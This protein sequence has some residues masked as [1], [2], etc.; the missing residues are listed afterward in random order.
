[1]S[2]FSRLKKRDNEE[3]FV[4]ASEQFLKAILGNEEVTKEAAMSIPAV[5]ACVNKIAQTVASLEVKLYEK[6]GDDIKE[7]DD[8]RTRLLNNA[9]GDTLTGYQLKDAMVRDMLLTKGGYAFIHRSMGEVKSLNYVPSEFVSIQKNA[10]IIYKKYRIFVQTKGYEGHQFVKLLRNTQNG[11]HGQSV[12]A[13]SN[14]EFQIAVAEQVF[15]RTIAQTGGAKKGFFKAQQAMSNEAMAKFKEAYRQLYVKGTEATM[16]LNSGMDFK[17]ISASS[18]ELQLN[19]NK[20]TNNDDICKIFGIPPS[21]INGGASKED[22][23]AFYEGCIYPILTTF[24]KSLNDVLLNPQLGEENLYFV[25]D[26]S[27]LTKAD[28]DERYTAYEKGIK[29]GFLQ[30]DEV[31]KRENLPALGIDFVKLG[32]QDV[33]YYPESGDIYTPNMGVMANT[34]DK[35]PMKEVTDNAGKD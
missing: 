33:L 30:L 11:W 1:M 12:I 29:N 2:I 31:R 27:G 3:S 26:A 21:I 4:E 22:R 32:L 6:V 8:P 23:R 28:I 25:F 24:A 17:E 9:T 34:H 10:D 13:D 16:V 14:I 35:E 19:Q 7:I 15:E 20:R 18:S 5:A